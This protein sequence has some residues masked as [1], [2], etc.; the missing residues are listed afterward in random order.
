MTKKIKIIIE[1]A[2]LELIGELY[3]NATTRA[4]WNVLP[5]NSIINTWGEEIYFD[6]PVDLKLEHDARAKVKIGEIAYWD[7]GKS[8]CVFFGKTPASNDEN[9]IAASPVNVF[10]KII[11][12]P[13][14][15]LNVKDK[16][17]IIVKKA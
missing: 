8:M 15:L 14:K 10:G 12:D 1:S 5:I 11:D 2:K 17:E 4:I 9:P 3:E 7:V 13:K 6:I 16:S